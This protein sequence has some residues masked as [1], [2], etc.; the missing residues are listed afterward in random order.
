MEQ[1]PTTRLQKLS[2][3]F[4]D[5]L[6]MQKPNAFRRTDFDIWNAHVDYV[7]RAY[8]DFC[9]EFNYLMESIHYNE[10]HADYFTTHTLFQKVNDYYQ[11]FENTLTAFGTTLVGKGLTPISSFDT[12]A[13]QTQIDDF[14]KR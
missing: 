6:S 11:D 1:R 5:R 4:F 10:H 8:R 12:D 14:E 9:K 7:R 13:N 3:R 2:A